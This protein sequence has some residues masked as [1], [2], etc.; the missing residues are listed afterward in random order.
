MFNNSWYRQKNGVPTGGTLCVQLANIAVYYVLSKTLYNNPDLMTNILTIKRYID[1]GCGLYYGSKEMFYNWITMVNTLLRPFGLTIDEFTISDPGVYVNFLNI[2]FRFDCIGD[3]QTDLYVKPTDARSYLYYGS[4]HP[5]HVFAGVL[6]S[7]CLLLR[8]IINNNERLEK[9][10]DELKNCF[11]A[12]AYPKKMVENIANKVKNL[13]RSLSKKPETSEDMQ[14]KIRVISTFQADPQITKVTEAYSHDLLQTRSFA[15][16]SENLD[17]SKTKI[18]QY[19]KRTGPSLMNKLDKS[20][21]LAMGKKIKTQPC[22]K[23]KCQLC[24]MICK[25]EQ[26]TFNN[27]KVRSAGGNCTT[28]NIVYLLICT[29]CELSYI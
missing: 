15:K 22:H 7:S 26:L 18:F 9:Q 19:V 8:R 13:K 20:K 12:C 3:L 14:N 2:K 10:L 21:E 24:G 27:Y 11:I 17:T 16:T 29:L 25:Q 4:S 28:S 5:N 23:S 1:D 6:Y